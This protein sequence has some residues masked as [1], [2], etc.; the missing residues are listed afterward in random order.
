[1]AIAI[2]TIPTLK[3]EEAK[4]FT[5]KANASYTRKATVDFSKQVKSARS[6]LSKAKLR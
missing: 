3:E 1:M 6:I 2:K 5:V 4:A